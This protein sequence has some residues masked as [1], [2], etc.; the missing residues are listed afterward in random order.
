MTKGI[1]LALLLISL[2][3]NSACAGQSDVDKILEQGLIVSPD[4]DASGVK[5]KLGDPL[6]T[7]VRN[8]INKYSEKNDHIETLIYKDAKIIIYTFNH[9]EHG[10]SKVAQVVV[11]GN[12]YDIP[13]KIG[14]PK[15]SVIELLGQSNVPGKE[16]IWYYFPSDTEPHLQ[17]I[18]KFND[19]KVSEVT[20]SHMP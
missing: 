17:L 9:P 11:S 16:A 4:L 10:W 6:N 3:D 12:T 14:M 5:N 20:W 7:T 8:V 1:F 19:S 13:V 15:S 2:C 18:I